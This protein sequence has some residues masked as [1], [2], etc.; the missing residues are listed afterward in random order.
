MNSEEFK[1][2][3]HLKNEIDYGICAPKL[4]GRLWQKRKVGFR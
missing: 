4:N 1:K 3:L 2:Q